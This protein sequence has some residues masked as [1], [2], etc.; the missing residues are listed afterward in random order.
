[1]NKRQ[2]KKLEKRTVYFDNEHHIFCMFSWHTVKL[3][4]K[5]AKRRK[6]NE[7]HI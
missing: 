3:L 1:M 4:E 2:A 5:L 7:R 6:K